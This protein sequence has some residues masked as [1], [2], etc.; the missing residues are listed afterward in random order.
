MSGNESASSLSASS[1]LQSLGVNV[2]MGYGNTVYWTNE[3]L[4][5]SSLDYL[6]IKHVRD[7]VPV[8]W[9]KANVEKLAD[10]GIKFDLYTP[11]INGAVDVAANIAMIDALAAAHPGMITSIE[12]PN[13]ILLRPV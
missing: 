1:F 10:H 13:E 6:G 7:N 3:H 2:H 5:E 9:T 12:G 4:V 11:T 8:P